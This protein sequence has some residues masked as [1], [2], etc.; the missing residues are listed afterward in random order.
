MEKPEGNLD[1]LVTVNG[2][3]T[4]ISTVTTVATL[5]KQLELTG[6][7]AVEINQ[8]IISRSE[9]DSHLLNNGDII[10]IVHAIGGG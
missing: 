3:A 6:R 7:L 5:L 8:R 9:F 2:V 1:L 10:E 4:N